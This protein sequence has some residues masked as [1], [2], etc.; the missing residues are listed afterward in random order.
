MVPDPQQNK[1]IPDSLRMVLRQYLEKPEVKSLAPDG[2]QCDAE[3]RGLLRRAVIVAAN[4]IPVGKETDRHWEQG[5]DPSMMDF[6][7]QVFGPSGK[8]AVADSSERKEWAK[9]GVRQLMRATRLTQKTV[10]FHSFGHG[11]PPP[12]YGYVSNRY[13]FASRA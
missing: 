9:I 11:C 2:T 7:I 12:N 4:V 8:L 1:V 3:T 13:R 5:E 10:L 6:N